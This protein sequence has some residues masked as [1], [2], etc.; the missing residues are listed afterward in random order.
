LKNFVFCRG[1]SLAKKLKSS[2]EGAQIGGAQ[3]VCAPSPRL[4]IIPAGCRN[5]E[6][7]TGIFSLKTPKNGKKC[8][9][10]P[11]NTIF[12]NAAK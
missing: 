10:C 12:Q 3:G 6:Q 9:F 7:K 4:T 1:D 8:P 5:L 2:I 11:E